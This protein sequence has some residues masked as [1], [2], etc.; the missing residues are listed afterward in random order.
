MRMFGLKGLCNTV[1]HLTTVLILY[2]GRWRAET[3][4]TPVLNYAAPRV[5][6]AGVRLDTSK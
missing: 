5:I 4:A 6:S 3:A 1:M 2:R